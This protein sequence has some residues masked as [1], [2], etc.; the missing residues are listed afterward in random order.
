M[1]IKGEVV[2]DGEAIEI[3]ELDVEEDEIGL[4]RSGADKGGRAVRRLADDL[5][6]VGFKDRTGERP[7]ARVIVNDQDGAHHQRIV[8]PWMRA[9]IRVG[10]GAA[11][12][13]A[14][15]EPRVDAWL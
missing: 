1:R 4:K 5:E 11:L 14:L 10:T 9:G 12:L 3:G 7:K 8:A 6:T 2:A 15:G 13:A